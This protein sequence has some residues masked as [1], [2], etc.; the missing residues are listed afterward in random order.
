M[1][2]VLVATNE[3][4]SDVATTAMLIIR[5]NRLSSLM[6]T[7][8][9]IKNSN[10]SMDNHNLYFNSIWFF[11]DKNQVHNNYYNTHE[12]NEPKVSLPLELFST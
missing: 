8:S 7:R 12:G 1:Y 4:E 5:E 9:I 3:D 10:A 11:L 2:V 6:G